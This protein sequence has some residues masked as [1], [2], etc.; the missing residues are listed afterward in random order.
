MEG[1][2]RMKQNY[3]TT[4]FYGKASGFITKETWDGLEELEQLELMGLYHMTG[5]E[6]EE[7]LRAA[8]GDLNEIK[9]VEL[10]IK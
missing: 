1:G 3:E 4:D 8:L 7:S 10:I 5:E 2:K 6:V 9:R